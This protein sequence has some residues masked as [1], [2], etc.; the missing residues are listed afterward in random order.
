MTGRIFVSY[1]RDTNAAAAGRL[2]D[3]LLQ[4]FGREQLFMDVEGIEPGVDFVK[5]LNER[6]SECGALLAV[7]GPGW[8]GAKD[9]AGR[10]RLD[11]P[12]DYVRL[13]IE[14]ALNRDVRVIPILVD[15]AQMPPTGEL[16]PSLGAFARRQAVEISHT[17]FGADTDDLAQSLRRALG[18]Q[19]RP[20]GT[21]RPVASLGTPGSNR[22]WSY[23]LFS[24]DGR[25]ARKPY[26]LASLGVT[27]SLFVWILLVSFAL[28]LAM[29]AAGAPASAFAP[30]SGPLKLLYYLLMLPFYWPIIALSLKRLHDIGQGWGLLAPL[31]ALLVAQIALDIAGNEQG[32]LMA[33]LAGT[34]AWVVIG[35]I[36]GT[37]GPNQYGPDPLAGV[38]TPIA[39]AERVT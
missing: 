4:H 1:R 26:W 23:L 32:S 28:A 29:F 22:G 33:M 27:V 30:V 5:V 11:D 25:L 13:E 35:C 10:R 7:I 37:P 8:A 9:R 17:R 34:G 36:K 6:L 24:F 14:A 15:G 3:R 12:N 39:A 18:I 21:H 2:Y 16:P 19:S 20:P 38:S 31:L